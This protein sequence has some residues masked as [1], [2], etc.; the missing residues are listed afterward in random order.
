MSD[1]TETLDIRLRYFITK[2]FR[3]EF[4]RKERVNIAI[5]VPWFYNLLCEHAEDFIFQCDWSDVGRF[6]I[7]ADVLFKSTYHR[8]KFNEKKELRGHCDVQ[9]SKGT[10]DERQKYVNKSFELFW[11]HVQ[12]DMGILKDIK[13][14]RRKVITQNSDYII[15]SISKWKQRKVNT[16][17]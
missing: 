8:N 11:H 15:K 14:E 12:K 9:I 3:D 10:Y 2:T 16:A 6:H 7:H 1:G 5:Y 4:L 17:L 13:P